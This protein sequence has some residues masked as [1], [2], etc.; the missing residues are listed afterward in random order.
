[1]TMTTSILLI[2]LACTGTDSF[3][4]SLRTFNCHLY[5]TRRSPSRSSPLFYTDVEPELKNSITNRRV[6]SFNHTAPSLSRSHERTVDGDRMADKA[7]TRTKS[8]AAKS[9][10]SS[11]P[12]RSTRPRQSREITWQKHYNELI[13]FQAEH[14][15][16][17]VPQNYPSNKKLGLWVMQ[18]RRQ[19]TLQENG[20]KS[21][22]DATTGK[23]RIE[24]LNNIGFVWHVRR[25]GSRGAYGA[26]G[27]RRLKRRA[28]V[29]DTNDDGTDEFLDAVDFEKF[30]IEKRESFSD[31]EM[32]AAW[33]RR[34]Q[35]FQ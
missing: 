9:K 19:Y 8:R 15:H 35:I 16:C 34:F 17:L 4:A 14:G 1:M 22:L 18:Q 12:S 5:N 21:S 20:K 28:V 25:R 27:L 23:K 2:L 32:R 10:S 3:S 31:E 26:A 33:R 6:I 7:A 30:M 29:T 13:H 11:N 24:L